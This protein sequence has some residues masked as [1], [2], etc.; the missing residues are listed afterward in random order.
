VTA[1]SSPVTSASPTE[2]PDITPEATPDLRVPVPTASAL[3]QGAFGWAIERLPDTDEVRSLVIVNDYALI[4]GLRGFDLPPT[5]P[6]EDEVLSYV[7]KVTLSKS[8][9]C[10]S[11]ESRLG[12][13]IGKT[14]DGFG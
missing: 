12:T 7:R 9:N 2:Q 1:V 10:G 4:R 5:N 8:G 14:V 13:Y 6:T 11:E 3:S